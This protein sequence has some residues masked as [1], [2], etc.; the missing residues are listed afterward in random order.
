LFLSCCVSSLLSLLSI[1]CFV[2]GF[3]FRN[4]GHCFRLSL[5][6]NLRSEGTFFLHFLILY[7]FFCFVSLLNLWLSLRVK[8]INN[9]ARLNTFSFISKSGWLEC[10][11]FHLSFY[12][13]SFLCFF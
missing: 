8:S 2:S 3:L 1:T 9:F 7:I 6:V 5:I 4:G 13:S 12:V 10:T 11:F